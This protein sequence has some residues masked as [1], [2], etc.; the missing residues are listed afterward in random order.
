MLHP[1]EARP[2]SISELVIRTRLTLSRGVVPVLQDFRSVGPNWTTLPGQFLSNGYLT[3]GTGKLYHEGHPANGDGNRSWSDLPVQF[4][5]N[6]STSSAGGASTYCDPSMPSCH[7]PGTASTPNPRWCAIDAP[8]SGDGIGDPATLVD[9]T[10]KLRFAAA[11]RNATGQPFFLGVRTLTRPPCNPPFP[12]CKPRCTGHC[13]PLVPPRPGMEV[14][15]VLRTV[16]VKRIRRS[17]KNW[18]FPSFNLPLVGG[19]P[20]AAY[21]LAGPRWVAGLV[22]AVE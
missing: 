10:K 3:L 15:R 13:S 2:C 20:P 11:N 7:V 19:V 4:A 18:C 12:P 6:K 9:A 17:P 5:C 16:D 21:G 1:F 14:V 8:L 22:P